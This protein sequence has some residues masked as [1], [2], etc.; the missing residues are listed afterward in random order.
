MINLNERIGT[1]GADSF[2]AVNGD[3]VYAGPGDDEIFLS[4]FHHA[5]LIGGSGNDTYLLGGA[6]FAAILDSSGHDTIVAPFH[7]TPYSTFVIT[8]DGGRHLLLGDLDTE[9]V[10]LIAEN[11]KYPIET[12]NFNGYITSRQGMEFAIRDNGMH[13]GDVSYGQFEQ[14]GLGS[15]SFW[16]QGMQ[17]ELDYLLNREGELFGS[18]PGDNHVLHPAPTPVPEPEPTPAPEPA[19]APEPEP[20]PEPAPESDNSN[21]TLVDADWYL[22]QNPDVAAAGI[23][24]ATHY[25]QWGWQE[26]R[27]PNRL[28]DTDWYLASNHDVAAAGVNPLE[29]YTRHG[30]REGRD[31]SSGFDTSH[32]LETHV[33]VALAG[34]NPL[35]HYLN[36]G[37]LEGREIA[38]AA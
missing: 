28:F 32:Y 1:H 24:A 23:D 11:H 35:E 13:L 34:M 18:S 31:P 4:P 6:S 3:I 27:D 5:Y 15:A 14:L 36:W 20:E 38:A 2:W 37:M 12:F 21:V 16:S 33:D 29:H 22:D 7:I 19:P 17:A 8:I 25:M 9:T 10:M 26:G 30:W